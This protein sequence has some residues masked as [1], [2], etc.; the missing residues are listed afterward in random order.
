[1]GHLIASEAYFCERVKPG[2]AAALP[3]GFAERHKTPAAASDDGKAFLSKDEY[4]KL[5]QQTR[6]ATLNLLESIPPA[7]LDKT[8]DK[9]PPFIKTAGE[10]LLFIGTHWTM[11]AG[12]WA[13]TRRN[14]GKPPLF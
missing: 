5:M 8:V 12:Q 6:A 1:L 9:V 11:H 13:V 4:L 2:S 14:L 10:A 3:A 7:E